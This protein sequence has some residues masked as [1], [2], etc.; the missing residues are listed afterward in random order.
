M[1][2]VVYLR[3]C[4]RERRVCGGVCGVGSGDGEVVCV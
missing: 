1:G 4:V 2:V 3:M